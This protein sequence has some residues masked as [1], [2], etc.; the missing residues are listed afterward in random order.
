MECLHNASEFMKQYLYRTYFA[1]HYLLLFMH[2]AP[3]IELCYKIRN[4]S[5]NFNSIDIVIV[6][7]LQMHARNQQK[8]FGLKWI[9]LCST[10]DSRSAVRICGV[11][12]APKYRKKTHITLKLFLFVDI[13]CASLPRRRFTLRSISRL[14]R[15][16]CD[17]SVI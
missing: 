6:G 2:R 15:K 16:S 17:S 12:T 1:L 3:S 7:C 11:R 10:S 14:K 9:K 5:L 13:C 8:C 4:K